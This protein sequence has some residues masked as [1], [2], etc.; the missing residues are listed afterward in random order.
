[1][2]VVSEA[3]ASPKRACK[4]EVNY[5][6]QEDEDSDSDDIVCKPKPAKKRKAGK[7]ST[8]TQAQV[9]EACAAGDAYVASVL[10]AQ[11][12]SF[13]EG[14]LFCIISK[15]R[16]A[17]VK[18]MEARLLAGGLDPKRILW[19]VGGGEKSEYEAAGAQGRVVEGGGLC[20]SRNL[21]LDEA[22]KSSN[23]CVQ[24]SDDLKKC[25]V[26]RAGPTLAHFHDEAL[27]TKPE[28]LKKANAAGADKLQATPVAAAALLLSLL[29]ATDRRL[30]GCYPNANPGLA[31]GVAP[32]GGHHFIVGDC[33]VVDVARTQLRFDERITL[34][35]DYDYT[36]QHMHEHGAVC[37]SNRVLCLWE[38]YSNA[39]GA[40]DARCDA[41]EQHSIALLKH[42]WPGAFRQHGTRGPNEVTFAWDQRD[43]SLGGKKNQPRPPAP[44]G[45]DD[46]PI[47]RKP[48]DG[49]KTM[50]SFFKKK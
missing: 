28:S 38:H 11:T 21:A 29:K 40:V 24:L 42:K 25:E 44:D 31:A 43:V 8:L 17:N 19:I 46:V 1:M 4:T 34:K 39:G 20:N 47:E 50:T 41:R 37:R 10:G 14:L 5:E 13:G 2:A 18:P 49:Q 26:V 23:A 35:E 3:R 16:W 45:I 48:K 6:N 15:S 22:R 27:W 12:S 7:A 33:L 32:I 30:A 36:A 9:E